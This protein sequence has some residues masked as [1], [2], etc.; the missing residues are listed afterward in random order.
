M[1]LG[2]LGSANSTQKAHTIEHAQQTFLSTANLVLTADAERMNNGQ[3]VI[4]GTTNLPDNLKMWVEVESG[5]LPLG[6]PNVVAS[7]D[8]VLIKDRKFNT[9]PLWLEVPNTRFTKKGWPKSVK[10]QVREK[11]FPAG[12]Y[13]VHFEGFFNGAWQTKE[14]LAVL[15]NEEGKNLKGQI[16]KAT[17]TDVIDSPKSLDYRQMVSFAPLN[18]EAK[19]IALVRAAILTVPGKGRSAGDIQANLD[20][21]LDS[22]EMRL[23]KEWNAEA[24]TPTTYEVSYDFINGSE[25]EQ[26]ATW[27][28]N[29]TT[30][31]VKYVNE[32]AKIFSWTPNY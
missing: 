13:K 14:V 20:L 6:A 17:D 21:Y 9:V 30:K 25:G 1:T 19:A 4:S 29:L 26:Q 8:D 7:D 18:P 2:C 27:I 11:P 28:A 16:L 12:Q 32:N 3:V 10:V 31:E 5:R 15:G 24:K 22:P 23:G